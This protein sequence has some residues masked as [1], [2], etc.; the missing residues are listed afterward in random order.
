[1]VVIGHV[2][3]LNGFAYMCLYVFRSPR[4]SPLPP[5]WC[6]RKASLLISIAWYV[7]FSTCC[8]LPI[9]FHSC[10]HHARLFVSPLSNKY[11]AKAEYIGYG[12][13]SASH[14]TVCPLDAAWVCSFLMSILCACIFASSSMS[15]LRPYSLHMVD[16]A[17]KNFRMW[18][19]ELWIS[20]SSPVSLCFCFLILCSDRNA[21]MSPDSKFS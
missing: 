13:G 8:D 16:M 19:E 10:V 5:S 21:M 11:C 14:L 17:S 3:T 6:I 12:I 20:R 9:M 18:T 1:M 2:A 7:R 4:W 15:S